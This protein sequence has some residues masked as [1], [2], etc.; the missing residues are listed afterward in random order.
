[1]VLCRSSSQ[2]L[3]NDSP[4]RISGLYF[5]FLMLKSHIIII[6]YFFLNIDIL[7]IFQLALIFQMLNQSLHHLLHLQRTCTTLSNPIE[8]WTIIGSL[9][10]ISLTRLDIAFAVSKLSQFMHRFTSD[11]WTTIK[12]LLR[13][14]CGTSS[15]G[16]VLYHNSSFSS[17]IFLC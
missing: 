7:A 6:G 11:H 9:Q 10:Y 17:R 8:Y 14:L 1:M 12:H 16:L 5:I 4:L 15:H 2:L 13:Y 3:P